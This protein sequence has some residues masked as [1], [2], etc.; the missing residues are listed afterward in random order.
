MPSLREKKRYIVFEVEGNFDKVKVIKIIDEALLKFLGILGMS[1]VNPVVMDDKFE[2]NKGIIRI[3]H[4]FKD[5]VIVGLGLIQDFKINILGVSG[6]LKK[7]E[8]KFLKR[9]E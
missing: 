6:I 7:A 2:K 9:E 5:E 1:K 8:E 4:G 3:N